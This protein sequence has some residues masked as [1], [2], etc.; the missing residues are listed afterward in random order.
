M[1]YLL[2][3]LMLPAC[4][5]GRTLTLPSGASYADRGHLAGNTTVVITRDGTAILHNK[6]NQ[7]FQDAMQLIGAAL[8]AKSGENV[9]EAGIAASKATDIA[10][11]RAG[12]TKAGFK[13]DVEKLRLA[14]ELEEFR[15]LHP[16]QLPVTP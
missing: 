3:V 2:P 6:M 14:K 11:T 1:K 12:V 9:A 7:P 8:V 10:A 5:T 16:A 13:V 4:Q 15:L